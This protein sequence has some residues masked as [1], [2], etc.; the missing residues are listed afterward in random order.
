MQFLSIIMNWCSSLETKQ[1]PNRNPYKQ[2]KNDFLTEVIFMAKK[3]RAQAKRS[4]AKSKGVCKPS[5]CCNGSNWF[6]WSLLALGV[7]FGLVE[8][9]FFSLGGL[10][11]WPILLLLVGIKFVKI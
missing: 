10:S 5:A 1:S 6:G 11:L 8:L 4:V 2:Q 7:V 3:K 9:G